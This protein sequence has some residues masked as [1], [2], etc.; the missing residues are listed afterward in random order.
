MPAAGLS[1]VGFMHREAALNHLKTACIPTNPSDAALEAEWCAAKAKL[2]AP[3]ANAGAPD[4]QPI[5]Q[6]HEAYVE[7]LKALPWVAAS[8]NGIFQGAEFKMIEI[9]PL[10]AFQFVVSTERSSHHCSALQN[11]PIADQL[12]GVALPTTLPSG[13]FHAL[14]QD[15][16]VIIKSRSLNLQMTA[17]GLGANMAGINFGWSIPLV[18]VVRFENRCYL[19]NGFHRTFGV[20][21][22]GATH[23]PCLFRTVNKL[24]DVGIR[25]DG[26]TFTEQAFKEPHQPTVGHFT[27]GRSCN[28]TLRATTRILHISWAEYA[29][30][31]E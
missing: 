24:E 5:P 16:S 10:L 6:S 18:H 17:H 14:A 9:D 19:F 27:Q 15:H 25:A 4:I 1:L 29:M 3:F 2:G 22:A 20:G 31:D 13:E 12:F 30:Y 11:P 23:V 21:I 28:V 7:Q 8:L 26:S